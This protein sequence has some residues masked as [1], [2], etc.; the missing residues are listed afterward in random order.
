REVPLAILERVTNLRSADIAEALWQLRRVELLH[1][2]PSREHGLHAFHHPLIQEVAYR[3]LLHERRRA[4]HGAVAR[5]MEAQF[6]DRP[7]R[8]ALL[9]YHLE[10]AGELLAAAQAHMHAAFWLCANDATQALRSWKKVLELLTGLPPSQSTDMLRMRAC[11]QIMY[12]G[13]CEGISAEEAESYFEE[14]KRLALAAGNIRAHALILAG[15]GRIL[16][17][18]GSADEYVAKIREAEGLAGDSDDASLQATLKAIL[19]HALRLAG[20]VSEALPANV[21]A[22]SRAHEIGAL[23]RQLLGFDVELWLTV[24]RGQILIMLGRVEEARPYLDRLLSNVD[25]IDFTQHVAS[26]AYVD[27]A[28]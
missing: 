16:G 5:A 3:S 26:V 22:M 18:R 28:S 24:M 13:W 19:C 15:Y 20:R 8:S 9:A 25:Q 10:Q 21:E 2:L 11:G 17:A 4:L 6:K 12:F 27:L 14:A 1:E 23:D 7:E